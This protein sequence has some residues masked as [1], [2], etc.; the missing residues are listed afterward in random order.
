MLPGF[1]FRL[2]DLQRLPE[3]ED[4][5]LDDVYQGYVLL[6]YRSAV[7]RAESAEQRAK[8]DRRQARLARKHAK[9]V[10]ARMQQEHQRANQEQQRAER[11]A[12][13]LRDL[14][15]NLEEK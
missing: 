3:L 6:R 8:E 10:K 1:Q 4:L 15:V 7:A 14:G 12:A 11:Y 9:L 13:M 2:I 5:A